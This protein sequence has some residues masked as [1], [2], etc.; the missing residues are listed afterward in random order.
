M[1]RLSQG[2]AAPYASES[3]VIAASSPAT[4]G[5]PAAF[6]Q[7]KSYIDGQGLV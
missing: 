6:R 7:R 5:V 1:T 2:L 3:A 4:R